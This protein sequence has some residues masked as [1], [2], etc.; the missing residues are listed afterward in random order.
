MV[1]KIG[2]G[3]DICFGDSKGI[4]DETLTTRWINFYKLFFSYRKWSAAE[5][6]TP[7]RPD[8]PVYTETP[9]QDFLDYLLYN[10]NH[11]YGQIVYS[12]NG[13]RWLKKKILLKT[14]F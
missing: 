3:C 7:D 12:H 8:K 11:S 14:Y 10:T 9:M 6:N 4:V 5:K 2:L 13:G 1:E